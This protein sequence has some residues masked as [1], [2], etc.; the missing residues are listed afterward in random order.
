M[1]LEL[2]ELKDIA[3]SLEFY[4][5][6]LEYDVRYFDDNEME[7]IKNKHKSLHDKVCKM[8]EELENL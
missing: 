6:N 3:I 2:N 1:K 5:S 8:I 7:H 4:I